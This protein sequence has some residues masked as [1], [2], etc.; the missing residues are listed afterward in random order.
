M[1][2]LRDNLKVSELPLLTMLLVVVNVA[3]FFGLQGGSQVDRQTL[4]R[5]GNVPYEI[6]HPGEQC[7]PARSDA[8]KFVCDEES[9]QEKRFKT[10][11]PPAWLTFFTSMFMHVGVAALIVNILL[12][13]VFGVALEAGIGRAAMLLAYVVGGLGADAVNILV[14]MDAATPT[15]AS[16]GA[17]AAVLGGYLMVF[18][19]AKIFTWYVPPLPFLWGWI[20]ANLSIGFYLGVLAF[21]AY[22]TID[23]F[24]GD[25]AG[26][27][28]YFV[29]F[30]G[31]LAG[32]GLV[33]FAVDSDTVASLRRQARRASRDEER[34]V[35][36]IETPPGQ[37]AP[38]PAYPYEVPKQAPTEQPGEA[39]FGQSPRYA[40][41]T[42]HTVPPPQ[43][44]RPNLFEPSPLIEPESVESPASPESP[45]SAS[46]PG[47]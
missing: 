3:V 47:A 30:G 41:P 29:H 27:A 28:S 14:N 4:Q 25:A 24:Y 20:R 22:F 21:V 18:P 10:D 42:S 45:E 7:M 5:Y 35:E 6:S 40:G 43:E 46:P 31:F 9:L 39:I 13:V 32:V 26:V 8:N 2:P 38:S 16:T 44:Q 23:D 1:I 12:L 17:I 37:P 33:K 34:V 36:H 11:F 19:H 15:P